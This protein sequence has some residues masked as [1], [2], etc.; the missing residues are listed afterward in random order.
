VARESID[1]TTNVS[2]DCVLLAVADGVA[3]VTLNRPDKR[4]ALTRVMLERLLHAFHAAGADASVRVV[5]LRAEG[6][7]FCAGVDLAELDE[8]RKAHGFTEYELLPEVF[9]AI[10]EHAN[11]TIAVVHGPALAGGCE[12]ALHCDIRLASPAAGFGMPLARLGMVVPFYAAER[13]TAICGIAAARDLLFTAEMID[14]TEAYRR[15]MVTRLVGS[16]QL[17]AAARAL[18]LRVAANAPLAL[19]AIKRALSQ[20]PKSVTNAMVSDLNEERIRVSRSRDAQEGLR[21]FLERRPPQ[22][23]GE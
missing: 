4:N 2:S 23:V 10:D 6:R 16:E 3:T 5:L 21:A 18:A 12:L 15:G 20:T 8:Y 11:P 17:D 22:F 13:L 14:G 19:R 7:A 1:G 9:R